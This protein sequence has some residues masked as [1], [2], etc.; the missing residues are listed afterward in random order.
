MAV[1]TG[2]YDM[3]MV[4]KCHK[5][6]HVDLYSEEQSRME[7][8]GV[9]GVSEQVTLFLQCINFGQFRTIV[10]RRHILRNF[11]DQK[12]PP[13]LRRRITLLPIWETGI[14]IWILL[15]VSQIV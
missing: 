1:S 4:R 2:H 3:T 6:T 13:L 14:Q 15:G 5:L 10:R 12:T 7:E 8:H 9:G 11:E